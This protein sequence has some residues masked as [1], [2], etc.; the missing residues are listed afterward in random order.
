MSRTSDA[1]IED[2]PDLLRSTHWQEEE[3]DEG[4]EVLFVHEAVLIDIGSLAVTDP[5]HRQQGHQVGNV[6]R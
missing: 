3:L 2:Y 1:P 6:R 4:V 5:S